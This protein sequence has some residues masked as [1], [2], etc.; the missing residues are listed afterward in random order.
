MVRGRSPSGIPIIP[1]WCILQLFPLPSP[2]PS[3]FTRSPSLSFL[4]HP[5][6]PLS[7]S[8]SYHIR[9]M[10]LFGSG[11]SGLV[12]EY[13]T[14]NQEVVDLTHIRSTASNLEQ[15]ANLL[16]AQ[17]NSASYP[18]TG[19]STLLGF[20][21]AWFSSLTSKRLCVIS[22]HGAI[23]ILFFRL[24]PSLYLF[25]WA[26]W[27]WPLTWLTNYRPSVLWHCWLG[28]VTRKIVSKMTYNV[29]SGT[30]NPTIPIPIPTFV[31][32][33]SDKSSRW[34]I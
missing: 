12:V 28:H 23:W 19:R 25:S 29:S 17:A 5:D 13:R 32:W 11:C 8:W 20:H 4:F 22:L 33:W 7:H 16:C 1:N 34:R 21:L 9:L 30:L 2:V 14:R 10:S 31:L 27:Y 24:H 26:W 6:S 18:L 15:V 3:L